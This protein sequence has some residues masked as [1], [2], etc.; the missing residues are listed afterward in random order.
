MKFH[1]RKGFT[2]I[3]LL[4]VIAIIAILVALL[5]PAV[6]QAREAARRSQCI[7]NLKQIGVGLHNYHDVHSCFMAGRIGPQINGGDRWSGFVHLL[8]YI[9]QASLYQSFEQRHLNGGDIRPW[10]E[11]SID[12]IRPTTVDIPALLCPSDTYL[13]R[14]FG[15]QAGNNYGFC[16]GDNGDRCDDIN[17]RGGFGRITS[18]RER[19]IIDG[20]SNSIAMG[21]LHRPIGNRSLGDVAE[22]LGTAVVR[23]NPAGC[24]PTFD[25]A[26][27]RYASGVAMAGGDQ[28]RGYRWA[29]GSAQFTGVVTVLPP[30]APS[31]ARDGSDSRDGLYSVASVHAGGAHVLMFDGAAR[32]VSENI[33]TGDLSAPSITGG[34]ESP[35]GIWG[36][37]GSI[38]GEEVIGDF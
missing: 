6:Q 11:W 37:L 12:G 3:E 8:P 15:G 22:N 21:E 14:N 24:L 29:D 32:F 4:V 36:A 10:N 31:C 1:R 5:L 38:Q 18:T 9:D 16:Y 7:S 30:N 23:D 25:A 20:T 28:K 2:L 26:T 17:V 34:G 27:R 35:Y 13:K 33:D 19:D